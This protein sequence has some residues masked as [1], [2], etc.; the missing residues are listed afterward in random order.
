[1]KQ[2]ETNNIIE[3]ALTEVVKD[4]ILTE[5]EVEN[6]FMDIIHNLTSLSPLI[7]KITDIKDI[8]NGGFGKSIS[9][10]NIG[11]TDFLQSC[12]TDK[13]GDALN[14]IYK[15]VS[16]EIGQSGIE[17]HYDVEVD[18]DN[19]DNDNLD[20]RL[21]ITSS[22]PLGSEK[23]NDMEK[24]EN[25]QIH[26]FVESLVNAK[27]NNK[28]KFV[29]QEREY[30]VE[31]WY[32]QLDVGLREEE[33]TESEVEEQ[34]LDAFDNVMTDYKN[35]KQEESES[36]LAGRNGGIEDTTSNFAVANGHGI[37]ETKKVIR[38]TE[39][40]FI[41]MLTR[42]VSETLKPKVV[43]E[44]PKVNTTTKP[45]KDATKSEMS[46]TETIIPKN[47]PGLDAVKK[48]HDKEKPEGDDH[49]NEVDKKL[50][51]YLSFDGNNNPEFPEQISEDGDDIVANRDGEFGEEAQEYVDTYRGMGPQ[52]AVYD[53]PPS[54]EFVERVRKALMGDP[55][56]GNASGK[57]VVNATESDVGEKVFKNIEKKR[58][59]IEDDP[60]YVKDEQPIEDDPKYKKNIHDPGYETM[61]EEEVV[62]V[63]E[64]KPVDPVVNEEIERMKKLSSY[65]EK[66]Q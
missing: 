14:K 19:N 55:T 16:K 56:M 34:S 24:T 13:L 44:T 45:Y 43:G 6:G 41:N 1:M 57:D 63:T 33:A 27:K 54:P 46:S 51:D 3:E 18:V 50:K 12:G 2:K 10:D 30:D 40:K 7:D 28:E 47:V 60:M 58:K 9:F 42:I 48:A 26:E 53:T 66:T 23:N 61:N 49:F 25:I 62:V 5:Q 29:V 21:K 64:E 35:Y 36:E 38:L 31:E 52:D 17:G 15:E 39:D 37:H 20:I 32:S 11:A 8:G 59:N 22:E 4:R 65:N